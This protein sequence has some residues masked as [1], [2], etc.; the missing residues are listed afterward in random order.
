MSPVFTSQNV[1]VH[2]LTR[3]QAEALAHAAQGLTSK[4]TASVM[5]ISH[6][7]VEMLLTHVML[8]LNARNRVHLITQAVAK[9]ALI[10][11]DHGRAAILVFALALSIAPSFDLSDDI[12]RTPTHP[13]R[14]VRVRRGNGRDPLDQLLT[15]A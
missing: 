12:G 10:I 1:S 13:V 2:G 5:H 3:R 7:T 11:T 6:R 8:R 4:E 14:V 15:A 9:G